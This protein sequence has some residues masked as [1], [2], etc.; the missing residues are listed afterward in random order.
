[1]P[2][3]ARVEAG[4]SAWTVPLRG[5]VSGEGRQR[6]PDGHGRRRLRPVRAALAWPGRGSN[7]GQ[8]PPR[9][10]GRGGA[11]GQDRRCL[12]AEGRPGGDA[13]RD[14]RDGRLGEGG[15]ELR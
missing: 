1:M 5:W 15:R 8:V 10:H 12:S 3:L 4:D 2:G 11:P 6:L 9:W 13:R 14:G 7:E